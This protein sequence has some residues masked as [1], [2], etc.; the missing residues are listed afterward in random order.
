MHFLDGTT[1]VHEDDWKKDSSQVFCGRPWVGET[2]FFSARSNG[3]MA[4]WRST[5]TEPVFHIVETPGGIDK[6]AEETP[7]DR[8]YE[9]LR[10]SLGKRFSK[11]DRF[12][13]DH[14]VSLE[15][16]LD[17]SIVFGFSYGVSKAELVRTGGKLLGHLIGRDGSS[18]DPERSRAVQ[19]FA[20]LR[21][22]LH[23]QQFLGC[24]NWLRTYLPAQF[25][26]APRC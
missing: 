13:L 9:L 14:L 22:K 20:P 8:Y 24:S 12:L 2:R 11:A 25:G 4:S 18:P 21:E 3:T 5:I 19:E 10:E 23:V 26:C 6:M 7:T 15:A 16:F 1:T 17:K